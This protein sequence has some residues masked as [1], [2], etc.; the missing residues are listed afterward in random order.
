MFSTL[1]LEQ[2]LTHFVSL[3][4]NA[5]IKR[6]YTLLHI[7]ISMDLLSLAGQIIKLKFLI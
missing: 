4:I 5:P 6:W 7:N 2:H 1:I 3:H